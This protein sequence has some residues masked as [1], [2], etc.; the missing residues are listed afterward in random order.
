[1]APGRRFFQRDARLVA[2]ELLNKL[3]VARDGRRGRI[4]EVEAYSDDDPAAHTFKG[5]TPRNASMFGRA[6]HLYVY[7]SHGIHWCANV[8]CDKVGIGGGVLIRALEPVDGLSR[9]RAARPGIATDRDL[10]RG[11]GRLAQAMGIT[12]EDDGADLLARDAHIRL[13]DDGL[14]PPADAHLHATPR[15]GISK[16]VDQPWRW[17][18][19]G[20]RFLSRG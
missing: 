12:G 1:V 6:G 11:P 20:S 14:P 8:V 19:P 4:V 10:C 5:P 13:L 16:A 17:V 9:M 18:V 3:L 15:V 2:P 7:R